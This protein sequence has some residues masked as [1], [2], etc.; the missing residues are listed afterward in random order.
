VLLALAIVFRDGKGLST[1]AVAGIR[2]AVLFG[3]LAAAIA[4]PWWIKNAVYTGN[5]VY[6]MAWGVFGGGEWTETNAQVYVAKTREKGEG[7]DLKALLRLPWTTVAYPR[8]FEDTEVG[9]FYWFFAPWILVWGIVALA[10][11]R[12]RPASAMLTLWGAFFVVSIFYTYQ[13][14]R[15]FLPV[16]ALGTVAACAAVAW[17]ARRGPL[18]ASVAL[19]ALSLPVLYN[20]ADSARWLLFDTGQF[21][22][23]NGVPT[24]GT[25]WPAYTLGYIGRDQYLATQIAYYPAAKYANEHLSARDKVLLVGEHRKMHWQV[26]VEG[27]DWYD[28]PRIQPFLRESRT[29]DEV[30]DRLRAAGFTHLFFNLDEWG[31]PRDPRQLT[32]ES[33][34]IPGSAW[35]YNIRFFSRDDV[36]KIRDVLASPRLRIEMAVVPGRMFLARI[37][38]KSQNVDNAPKLLSGTDQAST[39]SEPRHP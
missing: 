16:W 7:R 37:A 23:R 3:L 24:S 34:P 1:A 35:V 29:G 26:P 25:H 8:T 10:S 30:L 11:P 36:L 17:A 32:G 31:W 18:T 21:F 13:S 19:I 20:G 22:F 4:S 15:F 28:L 39:P 9:P 14:N 5:P 27:N 12:R 33:P 2:R 38:P 6:P